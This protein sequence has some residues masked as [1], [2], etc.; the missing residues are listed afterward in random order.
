MLEHPTLVGAVASFVAIAAWQW[1]RS[2]KARSPAPAAGSDSGNV[3]VRR[4]ELSPTLGVHVF[5]RPGGSFGYYLAH[6][7]AESGSSWR[8]S[9]EWGRGSAFATVDLAEEHGR[10]DAASAQG[11]D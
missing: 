10:R 7:D 1:L 9:A 8:G 11:R 4:V 6:R 2:R 5:A 3:V